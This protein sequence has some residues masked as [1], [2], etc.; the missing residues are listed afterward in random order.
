MPRSPQPQR[1]V[2]DLHADRFRAGVPDSA[3]APYTAVMLSPQLCRV[4]QRRLLDVMQAASLDAVVCAARHHVYWLSGHWPFW[5]HESAVV[6]RQD[7]RATLFCA[8]A[9]IQSAAVDETKAFEASWFSTQRQEQPRALAE[10][11]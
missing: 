5:L 1:R 10:V 9:P 4:R 7:G 2:A 8:N 3:H 11:I 6:L